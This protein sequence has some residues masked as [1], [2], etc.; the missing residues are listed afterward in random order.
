MLLFFDLFELHD[1]DFGK[2]LVVAD[3]AAVA[4]L[5]FKFDDQYLVAAT[6][7]DNGRIGFSFER[8]R[9]DFNRTTISL[10]QCFERELVA[11][12]AGH[13]F[14]GQRFARFGQILFAAGFNYSDSHMMPWR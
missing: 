4:G 6:L 1:F 10:E 12:F 2:Q 14:D 5:I 13:F 9:A 7:A 8:R 11:G 3:A